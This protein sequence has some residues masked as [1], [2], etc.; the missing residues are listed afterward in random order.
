[1][2]IE[3]WKRKNPPIQRK[4]QTNAD[5][6]RAMIDEELAEFLW[7]YGGS[8]PNCNKNDGILSKFDIFLVRMSKCDR[9]PFLSP[10][11]AI[12]PLTRFKGGLFI[13]LF[14]GSFFL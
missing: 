7:K 5:R 6:I 1:M 8:A 10:N 4:P 12:P 9:S 14:G 13:L 11:A 3:E 2:T